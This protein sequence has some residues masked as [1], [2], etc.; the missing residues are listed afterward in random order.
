[1]KKRRKLTSLTILLVLICSFLV[2]L[3]VTATG[4]ATDVVVSLQNNNPTMKVN[5]VETEIDAGRG[6]RP[7][8]TNGRTLTPIRAIVEAF[9]GVVGW[10]GTT[11]TVTLAMEQDVIILEIDSNVAYLNNV[12]Y[13]LDV[14]EI[15]GGSFEYYRLQ[16]P[17]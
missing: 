12:A 11:Q 6:T 9:G 13:T 8:V 16:R 10:E 3:P 17:G 15:I 7:M 4:N 2:C 14:Y 1:M 5:G